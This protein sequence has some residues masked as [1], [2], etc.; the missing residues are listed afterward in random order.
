MS[1]DA[2]PAVTPAPPRPV[3]TY[4]DSLPI[5]ERRD[6]L[7]DA[8]RDNQVVIVAGET[9]SG[10]STQLP[11][12]CLEAGRGAEGKLIGHTQPRR[13]AARTI[14]E[15]VAEELGGE[16][17][18]TVGYQVRFTDRMSAD[19]IVKVM[20]DG[21]LL[22]ETQR[23]REL[24][25]YDTLII[26]EAHERSLNIDFL[27]G[28][29]KQLLPR[30]PDLKVIITS[31]TIDT[32][33]FSKHFGDAP[34]IE[35]SGRTY[36][37]EM[38]YREPEEDQD[39]V[40]AILGACEELAD[41]GP[42][43]VLVFLSGEREIHDTAD[44]L[45]RANLRN[46]EVLPLYARLSSVEQHRIF[47]THTGRRIVL[48]TNVAET[49]L[50]VPGVRYVVDAGTARISRYNTRLKVQ[51]LPIEAISQASANQRAGRCG[52]VAPGICIRL[53]SE[54]DFKNR[55]EF[56]EPE[57]LRTNLASVIL[58]M[59]SLGLG[60]IAAFPFVEP[61][62]SRSIKDGVDLLEELGALR[63]D[64]EDPKKRLT[65]LGRRLAQLPLDPRLGRMVL[66][67]EQRGCAREVMI[68]AAA[69][70][71][72]DPR[73]RPQEHQ[74]AAAEMHRRFV[75]E[76]LSDFMAFVRLWDHLK[77][78]QQELSGNQFRKLCKSEY[79]NYL[80]VREWQDLFSQ[81]RKVSSTLGLRLN[82]DPAHPDHVHQALLSGLL[83]H[84]GSF[85]SDAREFKG[86]RNSRFIIANGSAL[87][88]KPPKWV[89]AAEL[90]E[91]NRLWARVGARIQPQWIEQLG[92]HL[93]KR[94]YGDPWWDAPRGAVMVLERVL[95]YGLPIVTGRQVHLSRINPA[96]AREL[97]IRNALVE[98]EWEAKHHFLVEN[99]ALVEEI[100]ALE[101]RFRRRDLMVDDELVF[102]FYDERIGT[103]VASARHFDQWWKLERPK[104]PDLLT[105]TP[106]TLLKLERDLDEDD[107]PEHWQQGDLR[108]PVSYQYEPGSPD[109][110][111]TVHI[112]LPILNQVSPDGFEWLVPGLREELVIALIRSLPKPIRKHLVPVTDTAREVI[113]VMNPSDGKLRDVLA[114]ELTRRSGERVTAATFELDRVP[115]HLRFTFAI[116]DHDGGKVAY[117][118][119]L[120]FLQEKLLGRARVAIARAAAAAHGI[121]RSGMTA[122]ECGDLPNVVEVERAGHQVRGY[123]ALVDG[124]ETV[125]VRVLTNEQ[126]QAL[127]MRA[128]TRKLLLL[129][130][131][132]ARK[133]ITR[134]FGNDVK[135]A[136]GG[137]DLGT[138]SDLVDQCI[139]AA[140][141]HLLTV[142]GGPV[143]NEAAFETL[144][145][146]V[147]GDVVDVASELA[148]TVGKTIV[149]SSAVVHQLNRLTSDVLLPSIGDATAQLRRLV[150]PG[151]VAATGGER[152]PDVLRYV[153]GI[154]RRLEKL[155]DEPLKDRQKLLLAR[156]LETEY[157]EL[158]ERLAPAKR[159]SPD[160]IALGWMLEELRVNLF[161]QTLGTKGSISE[162]KIRKEL[163]RLAA[164]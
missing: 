62:D 111:A 161:A 72:Q 11:K 91:T 58:Q 135:L 46:T 8:I 61:P 15:R 157:T 43:D 35:V 99:E 125:S 134:E 71:I 7:L 151:F 160:A 116:E 122:W 154:G 117:S 10:K 106:E 121:E 50:T 53:Y 19:T 84:I 26:D 9:G 28:Y 98:R 39:Q 63:T 78:R 155:P 83:S 66:E 94:T 101:S 109:D 44:A 152:L 131:P 25:R 65:K 60:D 74:Q 32:A 79:L 127:S 23:D 138:V 18:S 107:F 55:P 40:Q 144:R 16:L 162:Q 37:V 118:K 4:P 126:T 105:M 29:L 41:E 70:S 142:H 31:A 3:I 132:V 133:V 6:E 136:L 59:T 112:P 159:R 130:V 149:A 100:R 75:G 12:L 30:R 153:R 141:D 13:V 148:R 17:G 34:I 20:T 47:Q 124:G 68:I 27:L 57:I 143:W 158:L 104:H 45:R 87:A 137:T 156:G 145:E 114:K 147:R 123:P 150:R 89:M 54:D 48:S 146:A 56:T 69:L 120:A 88:K 38:R 129:T 22:A 97:F 64:T 2:A 73:E 14:A 81:L 52:R 119:D 95:L 163:R 24:K 80:R 5:T 108:F 140:I 76:D 92:D 164:G 103:D 115:E 110:G 36:P 96:L 49:S 1:T 82:H 128:G 86:A 21:I 42:G 113:A 139:Y 90:V 51:R 67:A 93:V 77:A 33:T 102:A 85:D